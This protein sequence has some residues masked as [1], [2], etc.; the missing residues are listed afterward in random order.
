MQT[1]DSKTITIKDIARL[2]GVAKSTVSEVLNNNR[3]MRASKATCEKVKKVIDEYQYKP[4]SFARGL[5]TR[6]TY[7]L[8]FLVSTKAVPGLAN[9]YYGMALAGVEAVCTERGYRCMVTCC[10]LSDVEKFVIP[11]KLQQ[12]C[13]DALVL[14]G[15][16]SAEAATIIRNLGIPVCTVGTSLNK[17]IMQVCEYTGTDYFMIFEHFYANG[18]RRALA[19]YD[20]E[21]GR[22][23]I[24]DS[25]LAVNAAHSDD[26]LLV[27][28]VNDCHD[29]EDC[30]GLS[31]FQRGSRF[32]ERFAK[33][34]VGN[35]ATA[36]F[37]NDQVCTGF[38][39]TAFTNGLQCPRDFSI[40]A[41]CDSILC[42]WAAV[43]ISAIED[44]I[45]QHGRLAANLMIDLLD[46]CRTK[47]EVSKIARQEHGKAKL[48]IR[49][50]DGPV[51]IKNTD[52]KSSKTTK[53]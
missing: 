48:I 29:Q 21:K 41:G 39:Q 40:I 6:R 43:S 5:S 17:D 44:H 35:R 47:E 16:I 37:G 28:V 22:E 32:A 3:R 31:E 38:I 4:Q 52:P 33:T 19:I 42:E 1:L 36:V 20:N 8:G 23:R 46:K 30:C 12:R 34:P 11:D 9:I 51:P 2:A 14:A 27:E 49:A 25:I 10:D 45:F 13:V 26:P 7:Q 18:H 53:Y 15:T 50:S 24:I